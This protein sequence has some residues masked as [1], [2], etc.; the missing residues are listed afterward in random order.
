MEK[1]TD[2][3]EREEIKL[4][5]FKKR[6]I[7]F[8]ID[9]LLIS[10]LFFVIY[11]DTF[12]K[13]AGDMAALQALLQSFLIQ[14]VVLKIAYHTFF[15]WKYGATLG[16][17]AMKIIC[18]DTEILD[19]PS[20]WNSFVRACIRVLSEWCFYLGF[21]WAFGNQERQSWHD[22]LARTIVCESK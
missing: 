10:I 17:I 19:Y 12:A 9:D 14:L 22:K 2:K 3:L 15:V 6:T 18:V 13:S 16:K 5:P 11:Y 1:I 7:A 4:A 8:V 21:I 20:L